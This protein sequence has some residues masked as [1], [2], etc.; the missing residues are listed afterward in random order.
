LKRLGSQQKGNLDLAGKVSFPVERIERSIVLIRG[1]KV[2]I[3]ADLAELYRVE[4][5]A[6]IRAVKRNIGRFPEDFMFQLT[7]EEANASRSQSA[8]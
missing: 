8:T 4:T 6:L 2:M 7:W 3:D 5:G 1:Q